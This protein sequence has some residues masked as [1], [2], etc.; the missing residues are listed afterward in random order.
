VGARGL[1]AGWVLRRLLLFLVTIWLAA[2]II[3]FLPRLAGGNPTQAVLAGLQQRVGVSKGDTQLVESYK[4]RFGLDESLP[5]QYV[6]YLSG[7]LQF[8]FGYSLTAFPTKVSEMIGA[9]MPWTIGLLTVATVLSFAIGLLIGAILGWRPTSRLVRTL[10]PFTL[11]FTAI[12]YYLF[13]I[14][15]IYVFGFV[16][17]WFPTSGG[18]DPALASGL[19]W[20]F[21]SSVISHGTL[22]ALSIILTSLGLWAISMRGM[23]VMIEGEDYLTLASAKG[24]SN[25]RILWQY[26]AR[27]AMLPQVTQLGLSLAGIVSGAVLV[28][29]VFGYPGIG[30]LLY[31][32]ITN[33][34]YTLLY[35][36]TYILILATAVAVLILDLIYP[37]LDPRITYKRQ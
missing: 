23:M 3:F 32:A 34:D 27:N 17:P 22:P 25:R 2:T 5:S 36:L 26:A 35:G 33:N 28:E 13:G 6:H 20:P 15:L 21:I 18:S 9:A 1:T 37:L 19:N 12:P 4:D 7:L 10:L 24:L 30:S 8:D 29:Y 14:A 11:V 31:Q 16:L